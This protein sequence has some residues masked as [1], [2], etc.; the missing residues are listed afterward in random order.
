MKTAQ[1]I[2]YIICKQIGTVHSIS[3]KCQYSNIVF[4]KYKYFNILIT[5]HISMIAYN[6]ILIEIHL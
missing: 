2:K 3:R 4:N 1:I 5:I 6:K